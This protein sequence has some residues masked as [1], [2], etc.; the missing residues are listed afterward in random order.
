MKIPKNWRR[1]QTELSVEEFSKLENFYVS[2]VSV[3]NS[4]LKIHRKTKPVKV[5]SVTTDRWGGYT[6]YLEKGKTI[7]DVDD[8]FLS[9]NEACDWFDQQ[10]TE[11]QKTIKDNINDLIKIHNSYDDLKINLRQQKFKRILLEI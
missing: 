11:A 6:F 5:L 4:G 10:I 2:K 9:Y 1:N 7:S 8:Y 3:T